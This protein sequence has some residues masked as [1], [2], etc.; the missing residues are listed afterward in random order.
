MVKRYGHMILFIIASMAIILI[1]IIP[2]IFFNTQ[3]A[4]DIRKLFNQ[5]KI[6]PQRLFI[7]CWRN[8]QT[9]YVDPTMNN[10][11]WRKWKYRY[12]KYIKTDEDVVLAV[13]T[14]LA[15]LNDIHSEFFDKKKYSLQEKYIRDNSDSNSLFSFSKSS[16]VTVKLDVIAGI[17]QNVVVE[18]DPILYENPK[19]D[20]I[21]LSINNYPL[22]GMEMN[23]AVKLIR[24][25][26]NF[27][28]V[29]VI[30]NNKIMTVTVL[31]GAMDIN[32]VSYKFLEKEN[33]VYISIFSLMGQNAPR[34]FRQI[35]ENYPDAK[36]YIIDLRGDIGGLVLNAIYIADEIVERGELI[37]LEYRNGNKFQLNAEKPSNHP[38]EK[39]IVVL[40][41]K[42]TASSSEILAGTL[43][44]SGKA[45]LVGEE[46]FGKNA[47]QQIIPMPNETGINL[48]TAKYEFS[49]K[50]IL[51]NGILQPD[52]EV[53]LSMKDILK[54]KDNQL[55]KA[56][57]II[58][59][60]TKIKSSI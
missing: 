14:M 39:P 40:I 26:S 3:E 20:D 35:I 52:Y 53:K 29:E 12:L 34:D 4:R 48:T 32:K 31:S 27:S 22:K 57:E 50:S 21:I 9:L 46:T 18:T 1:L 2:T 11:D 13:N 17:V 44:N 7:S 33:I 56:I 60:T 55:E 6:A 51:K 45:I 8:I 58:K 25:K 54:G 43:K 37:T 28:K 15:S 38:I 24:G 47:I 49:N 23:S 19:K 30:R 41:N 59:E 5:Q 36:G 42:K 10:Q 16:G